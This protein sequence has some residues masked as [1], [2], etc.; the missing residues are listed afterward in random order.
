MQGGMN[1]HVFGHGGDLG[2]CIAFLPT[3]RAFGGGH[4]LIG[5]REGNNFGR[6]TMRGPRFNAIRP[7]LEEQTDY[8][9]GV[10]W[11]EDFAGCTHDCTGFRTNHRPGENLAQWQ[12]RYFGVE[13]SEDPWLKATP[14]EKYRG[15]TVIARSSRYHERGFPW[16]D[17]LRENPEAIFVG[18]E[19]EHLAFQHR[20]GTIEH[21][22]TND[23][24]ELAEIMAAASRVIS[25]QT[26]AWW[27]AIGLG[28]DTLQ[29]TFRGSP[30]SII[31][32]PN[33]R[34]FTHEPHRL[35]QRRTATAA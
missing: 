5:R 24:L 2:D 12:A 18:L 1:Q 3:I 7:L 32:R 17:V 6:E 27:I 34:Y 11:T 35:S 4:L 21:V 25:N 30:D 14:N 28:C 10:K 20:Y 31:K 9:R 16:P 15:A 13:I 19:S 33:A 8:I 23:L 22:P 29:E 26:A